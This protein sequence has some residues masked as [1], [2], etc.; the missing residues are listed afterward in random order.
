[1]NWY[2]LA[3]RSST[4]SIWSCC[5]ATV[6]VSVAG[7]PAEAVEVAHISVPEGHADSMQTSRGGPIVCEFST[8]MT[9]T[10]AT[11]MPAPVASSLPP[12]SSIVLAA[13]MSTVGAVGSDRRRKLAGIER[14]E[15][16]AIGATQ[17]YY[18]YT[19]LY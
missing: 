14:A 13:E 10:E 16:S 15:R 5:T 7:P 12:A 8:A 4:L 2:A 17:V 6:D 19:L 18:Y 1:M 11:T 3:L 9:V